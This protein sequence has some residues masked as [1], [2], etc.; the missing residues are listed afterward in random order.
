MSC[1]IETTDPRQKK[2][3]WQPEATFFK[4]GRRKAMELKAPVIGKFITKFL[5]KPKAH[6]SA[7][8]S[9]D[10]ARVIKRIYPR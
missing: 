6:R 2:A 8:Y 5:W 3:R 10:F 7:L 4:Y 1:N 9:E